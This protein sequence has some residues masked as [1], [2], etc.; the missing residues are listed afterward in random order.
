MKYMEWKSSFNLNIE[1]IDQQHRKLV[2]I[3]NLLHESLQPS[4]EEDELNALVDILNK[5]ATA[6]NDMLEYTTNHF[7]YE[8]QLLR[9][10]R[11][12]GYDEHK[13]RHDSFTSQVKM[14][15]NHFDNA[16]EVNVNEMMEYLKA[17][18]LNHILREDKK[19]VP[20]LK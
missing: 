7:K 12:P 11:Y 3:I 13:K 19:Y 16:I 6:I 10:N 1:T 4:T 15:K 17:W 5:E 9:V 8:E 20:Y 14:Y 18:L 2:E